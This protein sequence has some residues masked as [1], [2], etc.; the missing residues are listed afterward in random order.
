M[1]FPVKGKLSSVWRLL[2]LLLWCSISK[3]LSSTVLRARH[4]AK[5]FAVYEKMNHTNP[6]LFREIRHMQKSLNKIQKMT[7][8]M[9]REDCGYQGGERGGSDS[10]KKKAVE[11]F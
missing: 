9:R 8:S 6:Y 3:H 11:L 7:A 1:S 5:S 10:T 4:C 2:L